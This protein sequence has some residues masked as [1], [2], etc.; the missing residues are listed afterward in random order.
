MDATTRGITTTSHYSEFG[1]E[2]VCLYH[3]LYCCVYY[4]GSFQLLRV[5][6]YPF[7][8]LASHQKKTTSDKRHS[9]QEV[10]SLSPLQTSLRLLPTV[11]CGILT[12]IATGI[13]VRRTSASYLVGVSS[14]FGAIACLLM[15]ILNSN[16][17]FWAAA[18]IAVFLSPMSSDGKYLSSPRSAKLI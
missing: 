5:L 9:F 7:V 4:L 8:I 17:S 14:L 15:A 3:N 13:L 10:Q 16:W 1:L 11:V 6:C 12:N 2:A 18:F